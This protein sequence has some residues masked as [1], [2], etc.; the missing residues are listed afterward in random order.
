M[1]QCPFCDAEVTEVIVLYGGHCPS[2]FHNI[3]GEESPTDPGVVSVESSSKTMFVVKRR[4]LLVG[5]VASVG[6]AAVMWVYG[7]D[8][9]RSQDPVEV[10]AYAGLS[11]HV[12]FPTESPKQEL[13]PEATAQHQSN[14]VSEDV[15]NPP[16]RMSRSRSR[17]MHEDDNVHRDTMH[18][19]TRPSTGVNLDL[20][21]VVRRDEF[22]ARV[23]EDSVEIETMI[24]RVLSRNSGQ[25]QG[26]YNSR[27]QSEEHLEGTWEVSFTVTKSGDV[28]GV[29]VAGEG[30]VDHVLEECLR[31]RVQSWRFEQID[32]NWPVAV[33][34]RLGA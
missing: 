33:P 30:L 26:C 20:G 31:Q 7:G 6:M 15:T 28:A 29:G 23:L 17:N 8:S 16:G 5:A 22:P 4:R 2:C 25:I 1:E 24:A 12:D 13:L 19:D 18:P 9:H 11:G 34:Y 27:L 10:G 32:R 21:V 3:P 14:V